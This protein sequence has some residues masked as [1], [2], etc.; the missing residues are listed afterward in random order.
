MGISEGGKKRGRGVEGEAGGKVSSRGEAERR[1]E[2]WKVGKVVEGRTGVV[3]PLCEDS[4]ETKQGKRGRE[5][6]MSSISPAG[7]SDSF[8]AGFSG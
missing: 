3:L 1:K 8:T 2:D 4:N 5:T 7:S 6:G